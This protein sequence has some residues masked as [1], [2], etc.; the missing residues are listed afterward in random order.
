MIQLQRNNKLESL[1]QRVEIRLNPGKQQ[2]FCGLPDSIF[3]AFYG[4]AAGGGKSFA[5]LVLPLLRKWY[6]IP[7][8]HGLILRRTFPELVKHQIEKAHQLYPLLGAKWHDQ[9]KRYVFPSGAKIDFGHA[10]YESDVR[11]YDSAEFSYIGIDELTSFTE[12]QYR[13]LIS[14]CRTSDKR[15]P[16]VMRSA[17]NPG[18]I[19]HGWVRD[20]FVKPHKE[21]G[22][23]IIDK[24]TGLKR[25]FIQAFAS[26]NP[27]LLEASPNYLKQL[28]FLPEAE[29]RAKLYGDWWSFA[30]QVFSEFRVAPY[31]DEPSNAQHVIPIDYPIPTWCPKILAIDW[32][33]QAMTYATWAAAFPNKRII[34]YDEY[35][36]VHK[37]IEVWS[38]EIAQKCVDNYP[39]LVALDPSAWQSRGAKLNIAEQFSL[40]WKSIFG[41]YPNLIKADNDRLGGKML[42]HEYLR[43]EP[44]PKFELGIETY[45]KDI[46]ESLL[47]LKGLEIAKAYLAKFVP[48]TKEE[49]I[50]PKFLIKENCKVMIKTIPLCVYIETTENGKNIE[51]VAEFN[52]DDPYDDLRYLL[53]AAI[54]Y[55]DE[56]KRNK[57]VA[58]HNMRIA[59]LSQEL[60]ATGNQT[61]FYR[62]IEHMQS[63]VIGPRPIRLKRRRFG[64]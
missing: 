49:E 47:R 50:L 8:F 27:I 24:N 51:D 13:F 10:E 63:Q 22:K 15:L 6:E 54:Y 38:T 64:R 30:G 16:T 57:D 11:K 41:K 1:D 29:K 34:Q 44:L 18:N 20:R 45:D 33:Y 56:S 35:A 3:E 14:R 37:D 43:W 4:G 5:L 2:L 61:K 60:T 52:G 23:I 62:Q 46:Y 42:V 48:K 53:K 19:G 58:D 28:E 12:F 17:S 25:I 59:E 32:G 26:D 39:D 9:K 40:S 55:F 21:G 36:E 31:P 7:T